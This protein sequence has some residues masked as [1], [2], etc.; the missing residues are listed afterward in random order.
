MVLC[1]HTSLRT[2]AQAPK[3]VRECKKMKREKEREDAK[4]GRMHSFCI[5]S[6]SRSIFFFRLFSFRLSSDVSLTRSLLLCLVCSLE[7]S[8]PLNL[9]RT[10]QYAEVVSE[11][12]QDSIDNSPRGYVKIG[13]RVYFKNGQNYSTFT[14]PVFDIF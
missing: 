1:V 13:F 3:N 10:S 5:L 12:S 11:R 7:F 9:S 6:L 4:P 14:V 8:Q 2:R